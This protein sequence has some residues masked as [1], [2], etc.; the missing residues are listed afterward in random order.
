MENMPNNQ[1]II[2]EKYYE[3]IR[4]A[5]EDF[6]KTENDPEQME[7]KKEN[8]PRLRALHPKAYQWKIVDDRPVGW[9]ALV[10][11]TKELMN[12]FLSCKITERQLF[13][14]TQPAKEYDAIYLCAS[15]TMPE[16]RDK[17]YALELNIDSIESISQGKKLT[18]FAWP[19]SGEGEG[20]ANK[21][22]EKFQTKILKRQEKVE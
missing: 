21:I 12:D 18:L 8:I 4:K 2:D 1:E 14:E 9:V 19:I 10:P 15:F 7:N 5:S 16:H 11:T 17:G 22:E 13:D 20:L 6:F 3:E